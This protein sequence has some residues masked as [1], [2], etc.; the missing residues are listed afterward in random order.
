MSKRAK[1]AVADFTLRLREPMRARIERSAKARSASMNGEIVAR[2]E[3]TFS[4]EE[5]FD[6]FFGGPEMRQMATMWAASFAHS[7]Q[8]SAGRKFDS[9]KD[10]PNT[11]NYRAGALAVVRALMEGMSPAVGRRFLQSAE[12]RFFTREIN[13]QHKASDHQEGD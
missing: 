5:L 4:K 8:L 12:S 1:T 11:D 2:L 6:K 9:Q 3:A 13:A 7:L 10:T